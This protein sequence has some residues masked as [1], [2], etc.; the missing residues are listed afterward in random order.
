MF[1]EEENLRCGQLLS[2]TQKLEQIVL[3]GPEKP[4]QK[5]SNLYFISMAKNFLIYKYVFMKDL[6]KNF[7]DAPSH[8]P[9]KSDE[10]PV[11]RRERTFDMDTKMSLKQV[12]V[13]MQFC[14]H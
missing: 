8:H 4:V 5:S 11:L 9:S 2:E 6:A 10:K 12:R 3:K 7:L 14:F 1:E 13:L